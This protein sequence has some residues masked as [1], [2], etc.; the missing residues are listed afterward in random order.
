MPLDSV[1]LNDASIAHGS[2]IHHIRT[3]AY[4]LIINNN[5]IR[6]FLQLC[7]HSPCQ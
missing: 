2:C 3:H 4:E 1:Q 6:M 5:A 7:L